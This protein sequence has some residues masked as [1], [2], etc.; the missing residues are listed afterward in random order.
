MQAPPDCA[1][2]TEVVIHHTDVTV[3]VF[4]KYPASGVI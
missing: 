4:F 1:P 2:K 3:N